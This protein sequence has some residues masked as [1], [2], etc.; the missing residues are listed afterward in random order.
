MT[1]FAQWIVAGTIVI[2]LGIMVMGAKNDRE[3]AARCEQQGAVF[4]YNQH[5]SNM[6]FPHGTLI[7]IR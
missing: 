5:S 1:G 2:I 6:C 4:I 3:Q 7:P